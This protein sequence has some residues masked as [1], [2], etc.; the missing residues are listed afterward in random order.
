MRKEKTELLALNLKEM[1]PTDR[2][3]E[4]CGRWVD[5]TPI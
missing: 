5:I 4:F 3:K 2:L 1:S